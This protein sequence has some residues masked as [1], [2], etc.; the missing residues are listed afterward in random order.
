VSLDDPGAAAVAQERR[1]TTDIP[2]PAQRSF[3]RR[4]FICPD[5]P[6]LRAGWRLLIH[7]LILVFLAMVLSVVVLFLGPT[8]SSST[9]DMAALAIQAI[10][11]FLSI[12]LATLVVRRWIDRRSF[13]SLGFA[14]DR[15]TVFDLAFGFVLPAVLF[16]LIFAIETFTGWLTFEGTALQT[17]SLPTIV[18]GLMLGLGVFV[19]VG[20]YEELL[21]R[22]Y[23]LQNLVDGLN[24]PWGILLSSS[25]FALLHLGNPSADLVSTLGILFAG[26]FLAYGWVRTGKLWLPIGLHIGWNFFEGTVFGFPVSG[27]GGF[28]FIQQTVAGP[29][30]VTGG[31]FGPEAGLVVLPAIALGAVAIRLFTHRRIVQMPPAASPSDRR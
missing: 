29:K 27:T 13:S 14:I 31:G 22:G 25:V 30:L 9:G 1:M 20:W 28:H 17:D 3:L 4:I 24:L 16:G 21:S 12:T 6:R 11:L 5:E 8:G 15:T 19:L 26:I 2:Q 10:I 7:S 23:Q 18:G